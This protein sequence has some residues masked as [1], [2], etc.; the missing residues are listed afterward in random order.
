VSP[1]ATLGERDDRSG[2][3]GVDGA[4]L[5]PDGEPDVAGGHHT[6]AGDEVAGELAARHVFLGGA[7]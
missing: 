5:G 7:S 2:F 1:T 4:Q 3:A 6:G